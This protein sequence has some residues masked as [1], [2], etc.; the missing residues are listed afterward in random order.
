M[1]YVIQVMS[2]DEHKVKAMIEAVSSDE[3]GLYEQCFIPM[4]RMRKKYRGRWQ[5][6]CERLFPG[7]LIVVTE[8]P[9]QLY[10]RL[11]T[12]T[13]FTKML[14]YADEYFTQ[15]SEKDISLL[16]RFQINEGGETGVVEL[17]HIDIQEGNQVVIVD[18]PLVN[19]EG[20]IKKINLHKRIAEVEVD[21]MGRKTNVYMGIE[22]VEKKI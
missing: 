15:L 20:Q 19:M 7:Y 2:G 10:E 13:A 21:F 18:G 14:G 17:S 12:V 3:A 8:K 5:E 22:F 16:K 6:V 4:R 9:L 1:W 11:K